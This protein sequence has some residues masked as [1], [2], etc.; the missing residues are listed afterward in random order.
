M[1]KSLAVPFLLIFV[2]L[3]PAACKTDNTGSATAPTQLLADAE[4]AFTA[5]Q[6]AIVIEVQAGR[7]KG[8]TA[9][10]VR[11]VNAGAK[12]ALDT[13]RAAVREGKPNAAVL[14]AAASSAVLNLTALVN[15][16]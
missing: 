3:A 16:R 12:V 13:A 1:L 5:L 6:K 14:I 10:R 8:E 2:A 9:A 15:A 7:L 4:I 11:Q